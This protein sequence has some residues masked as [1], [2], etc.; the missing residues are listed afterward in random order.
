MLA[1]TTRMRDTVAGMLVRGPGEDRFRFTK[2]PVDA[3]EAER[4]AREKVQRLHR[5]TESERI[6]VQH[7]QKCYSQAESA[8]TPHHET[9]AQAYAFYRN[10]H[11]RIWDTM[12]R[13]L[14]QQ[15]EVPSYRVRFTENQITT[16]VLHIAS[17]RLQ[18]GHVTHG[19]P[20][21]PRDA[22]DRAAAEIAGKVLRHLER[23]SDYDWNRL[24]AIVYSTIYG[25]AFY[26]PYWDHRKVVE[27]GRQEPNYDY[28]PQ[29]PEAEPYIARLAGK[30]REG[31][32]ALDVCN[33]WEIF[34]QPAK[35]WDKLQWC[36]QAQ[37]QDLDW[38][39][40]QFGQRGAL[41]QPEKEVGLFRQSA[42][43]SNP[44]SGSQL[45]EGGEGD[46]Y[47]HS[48][49]LKQYFQKPNE[50]YPDGRW[51]ITANGIYLYHE[52][53]LPHPQG[54]FPVIPVF[55]ILDPE[56]QWGM[57]WVEV[58]M[59]PQKLLNKMVSAAIEDMNM[60]GRPKM[61][62]PK[63]CGIDEDAF[64][65]GPG[66]IIE[67]N[68]SSGHKPEALQGA[69]RS[70]FAENLYERAKQGL[71]ETTGV[72]NVSVGQQEGA[73]STASGLLLLSKNNDLALSVSIKSEA[74]SAKDLGAYGLEMAAE[75]Y[76]VPRFLR[77]LGDG[78]TEPEALVFHKDD[79][80]GNTEVSVRASDGV[81]DTPEFRR[82]SVIELAQMGLIPIQNLS[83]DA[84]AELLRS[85]NETEVADIIQKEA[86]RQAAMQQ[87]QAEAQAQAQEQALA[88][89]QAAEE[90]K[91]L[92]RQ[93][94]QGEKEV[95]KAEQQRA[96]LEE[97]GAQQEM[98]MPE[99]MV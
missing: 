1:S 5:P 74:K 45:A 41:V 35:N 89:Q 97:Q 95:A 42:G 76:T 94:A 69:T 72:T 43:M 73:V 15:T 44:G 67:Y 80:H 64:H 36:I 51:I 65:S 16:L 19:L 10:H 18:A 57:G 78:V 55:G 56:S 14:V 31:D 50:D 21:N 34:P 11:Y 9:W 25:T 3:E 93:A 23:I 87:Q 79:L 60:L 66:E 75:Y 77:V 8:K 46:G 4:Q 28:D 62:L 84:I 52:D 99:V 70:P 12:S 59:D 26:C 85:I 54:R 2:P 7:V 27:I 13:Q 38:I 63:E 20:N 90:A 98:E 88:D 48:A 58:G 96:K 47:G 39:R 53:R 83:M 68:A 71:R 32:Y 92:E 22:R 33:V 49:L 30:A 82:Q 29:D 91:A 24:Q 37:V 17:R 61:L 81:T 6:L 86:E 40:A